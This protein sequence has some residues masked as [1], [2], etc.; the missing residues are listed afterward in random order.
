MNLNISVLTVLSLCAGTLIEY[1][2]NWE[3]LKVFIIQ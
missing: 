3:Q 1:Q 2:Q